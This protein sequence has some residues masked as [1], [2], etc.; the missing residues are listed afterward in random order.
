ME[1]YESTRTAA[2]LE[3]ALSAVPSIGGNGNWFIGDMDTD[4]KAQGPTGVRG[5]A[6]YRTTTAPSSYTTAIGGFT[7]VYRIK[8]STVKS[9]GGVS[10][11][12]VGD[13]I[14]QSY[15]TYKVGYVDAD[16][17]YLDKRV[18]IRGSTGAAGAT[19]DQVI[20]ALTKETWTFTLADGS[21]V[22][23]VVPLI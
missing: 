9:E 20:A 23:K 19:V 3:Y 5:T 1:V 8:L 11:V 22:D 2:E 4:I 17:A 21:T 12:F 13:V 16:Y 6:M 15:Y 14:V 18:S 10:E 7:P